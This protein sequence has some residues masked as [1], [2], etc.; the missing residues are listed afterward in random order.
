MGAPMSIQEWGKCYREH[1]VNGS[2]LKAQK[3]KNEID[4]KKTILKKTSI[5][6]I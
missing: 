2:N 1:V 5:L 4:L 3:A 6:W